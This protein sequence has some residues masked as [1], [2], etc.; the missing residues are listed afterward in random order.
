MKKLT[1]L[2]KVD[3]MTTEKSFKQ[4]GQFFNNTS[5]LT[6]LNVDSYTTLM[7]SIAPISE[8]A[9]KG[10]PKKGEGRY[11]YDE[12]I[13]FSLSPQEALGIIM[14]FKEIEDGTFST[15]FLHNFSDIISTF[16]FGRSKQGA[17]FVSITKNKK[18]IRFTF[19]GQKLKVTNSSKETSEDTYFEFELNYF[20]KILDIFIEKNIEAKENKVSSFST[21][22]EKSTPEGTTTRKKTKS[23]IEEDE[24]EDEE[25]TPKAK[26]SRF[27]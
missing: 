13:N 19:N 18:T 26:K 7:I 6:A 2:N 24:E 1:K 20:L 8:D 21:A 27:N 16:A 3:I 11:N 22:K 10:K 17:A 25:E 9:T 14:F 4:M 5:T 12:K 23:I 15:S